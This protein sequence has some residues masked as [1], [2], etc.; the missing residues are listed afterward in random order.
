MSSSS[1]AHNLSTSGPGAASLKAGF[2]DSTGEFKRQT[3]SFRDWIEDT[4][5]AKFPPEK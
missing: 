1:T 2:A 3:S 5:G 4:P